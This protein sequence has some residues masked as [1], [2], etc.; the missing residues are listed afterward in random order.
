MLETLAGVLGISPAGMSPPRGHVRRLADA[1]P[2]NAAALLTHPVHLSLEALPF[3]GSARLVRVLLELRGPPVLLAYLDAGTEVVPLTGST[4][5]LEAFNLRYGLQLRPQHV[6]AYLRFFLA[7]TTAGL[8]FRVVEC[9][10]SIAW[11][12]MARREGHPARARAEEAKK[13]IRPIAVFD[14]EGTYC[15]VVVGVAQRGLRELTLD[16]TRKGKVTLLAHRLLVQ[17]VP[18]PFVR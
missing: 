3:Y 2:S 5:A 15:A 11:L 10:D 18:V 13:A 8:D 14:S 7:T 12:P 1:D 6:A 4:A 17:D 9:P 16:V